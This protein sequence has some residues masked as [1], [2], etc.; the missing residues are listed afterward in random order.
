MDDSGRPTYERILAN[1]GRLLDRDPGAAERL[2]FVVTLAPRVDL[3]AVA[4]FFAAFP[5]FI[6]RGIETRPH[7]TV[8]FASSTWAQLRKN[9][10]G[11]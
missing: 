7:L 8:N 3:P 1:L 6:E 9:A 11:S 10:G 5:P 2:S 4:D